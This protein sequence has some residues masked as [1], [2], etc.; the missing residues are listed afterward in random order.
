MPQYKL[1]V[2][3]EITER[4]GDDLQK[5]AEI[6]YS[7]IPKLDKKVKEQEQELLKLQKNLYTQTQ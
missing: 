5:V 3:A 1:K 2:T 4:K 7:Q 6:R